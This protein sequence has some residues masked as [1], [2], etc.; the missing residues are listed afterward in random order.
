MAGR[1]TTDAIIKGRCAISVNNP[2]HPSPS[3]WARVALTDVA[4]LG[5]GHTPSRLHPEYWDGD[6]P[7]IGI[8]DAGAHHG[9]TIHQTA[10]HVTALGLANSAARLLPKDTICLSRTASVGYVVKLGQPMATS[11]DFVT[12]S[13]SEAL[14]PDYL[15]RALLAEGQDI[16][17]FGEGST[18]TT[19][20]FP[21][22]KAFHIDLPPIAE[23]RR[24]VTKLD[25]LTER[26]ARARAELSRV[27]IAQDRLSTTTLCQA[28]MGMLTEKWREQTTKVETVSELLDRTPVPV[29]GRGGREATDKIIPGRG[30]LSVNDPGSE[31][32]VG[33]Q[34]VPLLRIARQETGHTPSRSQPSYWDGGVPWVG[35]RD[36]GAHHG[37]RIDKT[38]QTIS[39][40]GLANSSARLLP[41]GTVCL[42]RTASVGYVTIL[43]RPM[44][45]S[46]DFA[47]W[48]CGS[49]LLPEY[50]M[51][52][53]LAEGDDIRKFGM[54]STHTT[55]YFP[56][57]R[58]LHIAL[59]PLEEQREIV[60]RTD[61]AFARATRVAAEAAR[62]T[63][64][65][66]R[67]EISILAKAVRGE[68]VPQDPADEPATALLDR[69]RAERAAAPKAR[70]GRGATG[71][72]EKR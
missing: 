47:T 51:L 33:W 3:G 44:A 14:N 68:L 10:Q 60:A 16:C 67:L 64:L 72:A 27:T 38:A 30:G 63:A 53:L 17:R 41:A 28:V 32:P 18:H 42:S 13:C 24:I 7:W 22:V 4:E 36:A 11:Q 20:Y 45:T 46:Q 66:D 31:L 55:I 62:A 2:G 69:T 52:A 12:W 71:H 23:Q 37:R 21:E 61:A 25:T 43:D 26:V 39:D 40:E 6:V 57:I 50:L 8:R 54:G 34:W 9:G 65:L 29:Q 1:A 70:R 19:I 48:T 58:A 56:E 35:I 49:A 15:V 59:P 5:T